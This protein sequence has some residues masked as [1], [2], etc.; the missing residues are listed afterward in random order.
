MTERVLVVVRV[1]AQV[2]KEEERDDDH[3]TC[4]PK[5]L[6]KNVG[7]DRNCDPMKNWDWDGFDT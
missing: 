7:H 4:S 3:V 5:G 2:E 1:F 6:V